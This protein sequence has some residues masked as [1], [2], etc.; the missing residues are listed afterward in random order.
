MAFLGAKERKPGQRKE[1][2]AENP[3]YEILERKKRV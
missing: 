2:L 1:P 3:D